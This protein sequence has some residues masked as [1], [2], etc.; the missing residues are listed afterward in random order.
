MPRRP[1]PARGPRR[2]RTGASARRGSSRTWPHAAA[3]PR[4]HPG[5][6][7]RGSRSSGRAPCP[8]AKFPPRSPRRGVGVSEWDLGPWPDK[9]G[10]SREGERSPSQPSWVA[11]SGVATP[12]AGRSL[13]GRLVA[14][15]PPPRLCLSRS[16]IFA[17]AFLLV[18][19]GSPR[20]CPV[21][22]GGESR[23]VGAL[24]TQ[25]RSFTLLV[26]LL[27]ALLIR[28]G[29]KR[30]CVGKEIISLKVI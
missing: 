7:E 10:A 6:G 3:E 24:F 16:L 4:S 14:D 19:M 2:P 5:R 29:K 30:C 1:S 25:P 23:C 17:G 12:G 13:L 21:A 26:F 8:W 15:S 28:E 22:V 18:G 20:G 11:Q 9:C 27:F